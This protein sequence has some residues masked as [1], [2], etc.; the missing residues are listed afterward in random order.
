MKADESSNTNAFLNKLI[1]NMLE[2]RKER[3]E[4]IHGSMSNWLEYYDEKLTEGIRDYIDVLMDEVYF[5]GSHFN[6]LTSSIW[7]RPNKENIVKFDEII[8]N[9]TKITGQTATECIRKMLN[10]YCTLPQFKREQI[11]FSEEFEMLNTSYNNDRI[12]RIEYNDEKKLIVVLE[13]QSGYTYDQN[14]YILCLDTEN[15][16][17]LSLL[18]HNIKRVYLTS[19]CIEMQDIIGKRVLEIINEQRFASQEV[20]EIMEG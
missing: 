10:E 12:A 20:F 16:V 4:I 17:I 18:L 11:V 15:K 13:F 19:E 7:I 1:P 14:N 9:E 3:R 8:E 6:D 5:G 2:V